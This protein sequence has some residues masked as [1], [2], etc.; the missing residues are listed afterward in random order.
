VETLKTL[1]SQ[2]NLE[3]E[4]QGWKYHTTQFQ[5]I[6]QSHI[7]KNSMVLTQEQTK[8]NEWIE[9]PEMNPCSYSHLI[10]KKKKGSK[11]ICRRK[12]NLIKKCC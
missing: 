5:I 11:Y 8:T 2:S 7:N 9:D 12:D 1:N 6:L 4:K 3:Q 10:L